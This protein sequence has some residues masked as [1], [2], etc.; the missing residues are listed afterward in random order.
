L[1][2]KTI[3][4]IV[5]GVLAVVAVI[6]SFVGI[7]DKEFP[8]PGPLGRVI[9]AVF[10]VLVAGS[11]AYAIASAREEQ[12]ERREH[13]AEAREQAEGGAPA[14]EPAAEEPIDEETPADGAEGDELATQGADVFA[15]NGCG[16]C[17][18]LAAANA[19]GTIGPDLDQTLADKDA[20]YIE[21]AIVDPDA[22]IADG[23][24]AGVMPTSFGDDISP[25]DLEALIAY[26]EFAVSQS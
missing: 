12:R 25:E 9:L 3:F 2:A 24:N 15:A 22:T 7:R 14:E 18:A 19:T 20:A 11:A 1:D 10:A 23:F 21:E 4:Y 8:P 6:T 26:L 17:H 13:L 5:G 16:S